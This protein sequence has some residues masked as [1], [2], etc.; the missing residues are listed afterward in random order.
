MV[1]FSEIMR[2]DVLSAHARNNFSDFNKISIFGANF[3]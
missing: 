1:Y 2:N 3:E